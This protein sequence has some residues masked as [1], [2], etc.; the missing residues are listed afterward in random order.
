[1]N[2]STWLFTCQHGPRECEG[3][4]LET[5]AI[6]LYPN[7]FYNK[8]LPFV[9]CLESNSANWTAQGK[10]CAPQNGLDWEKIASCMTSEQGNKWQA[11]YAEITEKLVPA[12]TY[13]PWV[14][15]NGQHSQSSESAVESNM[16]RYVCS[17]Y[18]GSVQIDACRR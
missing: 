17:I 5:C 2:G 11:E 4:I 13:V 3:N 12:H 6:K 14:V 10:K 18:K 1:M 7:D 8:V 15:V 16:V 9:L